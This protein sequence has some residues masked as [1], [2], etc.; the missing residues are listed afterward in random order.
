MK[1]ETTNPTSTINRIKP[2]LVLVACLI[3]TALGPPAAELSR[4]DGGRGGPP[5]PVN[6]TF[7]ASGECAFDVQITVTRRQAVI[8]LPNGGLII[9]APT[10]HGTFTNLSDPT[11]SVTLNITGV[12]HIT[13]D[14]NGDTIYMVTGRNGFVDPTVGLL[15]LIGD[16]TFVYDS[17]GNLISGPTGS[18]QITSI[19]DMIN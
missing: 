12:F 3:L 17:N 10:A 5:V 11:K 16:F 18:G 8:N 4:A 15:L 2:P 19:C 9:N 13:F 6:Y 14:Q 1:N 7:V